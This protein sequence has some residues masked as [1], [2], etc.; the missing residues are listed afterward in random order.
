M[1]DHVTGRRVEPRFRIRRRGAACR[2]TSAS[3]P[4]GALSRPGTAALKRQT[5]NTTSQLFTLER[6]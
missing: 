1:T 2:T 4:A 6:H 3:I 5:S